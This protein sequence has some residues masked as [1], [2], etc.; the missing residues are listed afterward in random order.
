[1]RA[2]RSPLLRNRHAARCL[3]GD[4]R[5]CQ[6]VHVVVQ[7]AETRVVAPGLLHELEL[8]FQAGVHAEEMH[9]SRLTI[10]CN[11]RAGSGAPHRSRH[12]EGRR[13]E[14][15]R[16]VD[17][18]AAEQPMRFGHAARL[19]GRIRLE[20][21][22]RVGPTDVRADRAAAVRRDRRRRGNRLALRGSRRQRRAPASSVRQTA[23]VRRTW[24]QATRCAQHRRFRCERPL[25]P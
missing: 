23:I 19:R 11:A 6:R 10:V 15:R 25:A 17:A 21:I 8:T 4:R 2:Q 13:V 22:T 1:M 12:V 16:P 14:Q 24:R 20:H 7:T 3:S 5:A 9:A 18:P